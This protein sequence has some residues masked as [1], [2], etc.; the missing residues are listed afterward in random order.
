MLNNPVNKFIL[1]SVLINVIL[2]VFCVYLSHKIYLLNKNILGVSVVAAK[3]DQSLISNNIKN[4]DHEIFII[5]LSDL[6][7]RVPD[8]IQKTFL[9]KNEDFT[10]YLNHLNQREEVLRNKGLFNK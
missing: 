1:A 3:A 4:Q 10:L 7:N 5:V 2:S 6:I 8:N 9:S